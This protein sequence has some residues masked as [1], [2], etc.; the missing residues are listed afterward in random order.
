MK[1]IHN[2][3][4][5]VLIAALV[6]SPVMAKPKFKPVET[7]LLATYDGNKGM[8][9]SPWLEKNV[10]CYRTLS[11]AVHVQ[12]G[13]PGHTAT[14]KLVTPT[15]S[16]AHS[17]AG[18]QNVL[19]AED[20]G[21]SL[22]SWSVPGMTRIDK[23]FE[24]YEGTGILLSGGGGGQ[25][26]NEVYAKAYWLFSAEASDTGIIDKPDVMEDFGL[27]ALNGCSNSAENTNQSTK[28][29]ISYDADGIFQFSKKKSKTKCTSLP[30]DGL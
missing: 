5:A 11:Q 4:A 24:A 30:N 9:E 1:S 15:C 17:E 22:F 20:E 28:I 6:A 8:P 10:Y 14:V 18:A 7:K 16:S 2:L 3:I 23:I 21:R 25:G 29:F 19:V 26:Y 27:V 12:L 13:G